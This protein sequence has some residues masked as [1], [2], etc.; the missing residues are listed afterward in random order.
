VLAEDPGVTAVFAGNDQ[1]ALGVMKAMADAGRRIPGDVSVVGFDGLPE[2][3][4]FRPGLSTVHF[5]FGEVGRRAVTYILD[6]IA[7]TSPPVV[8]PIEPRLVVRASAGSAAR[9]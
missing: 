8:P 9:G 6:L 3:P 7:G 2:S 5:D 4:F 1:M